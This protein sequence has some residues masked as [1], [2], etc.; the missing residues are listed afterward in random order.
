MGGV[1]GGDGIRWLRDGSA[2]VQRWFAVGTATANPQPS[3]STKI[4]EIRRKSWEIYG[5][6]FLGKVAENARKDNFW[7][8]W[9]FGT[10]MPEN[11][12]EATTMNDVFTSDRG[13]RAVFLTL[14]NSQSTFSV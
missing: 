6:K 1:R 10:Y 14:W 7:E 5:K 12:E 13:L 2:M 8:T 3:E 4:T 9:L 11:Q